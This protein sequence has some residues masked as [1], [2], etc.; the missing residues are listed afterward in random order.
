[1]AATRFLDPLERT[2]EVLFGLIMVVGFTA[3]IELT[4]SAADVHAVLVAAL[5]CNIAWGVVDAA[6]FLMARF[7]ERSRGLMLLSAVRRARE[8][9]VARAL[10]A[11]ELPPGLAARLG[12]LEYD[13]IRKRLQAESTPI[14]GPALT[15]DDC[16]GALGVFA[17]VFFSTLP[18]AAPF[19][20][21]DDITPAMRASHA[22]AAVLLF[23]MGWRLGIYAGR[24]PWRTG[25]AMAGIG[26]ILS[27]ITFLLGG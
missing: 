16:M 24:P 18:V 6:M 20:V 19:I 7:A 5:G 21:M 8:P 10:I 17:L 3:S 12:S 26:A 22:I 2:L 14:K 27:A 4:G 1:M 13:V 23:I 9:Q 15:Y 11:E 25:V